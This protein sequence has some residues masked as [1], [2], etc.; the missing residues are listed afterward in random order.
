M[1][2]IAFAFALAILP[3]LAPLPASGLIMSGRGNQPVNDAGWPEG[4]LAMA[5]FE[6]RIG[7]WEGP[8]FGGGES[9]FLFC[10]NTEGFQDAL[11]A[12]AAIRAP[13]LDLVIHDGPYEDNILK[14][15]VDWAF[16]V[17][18]PASWRS[19]EHTSE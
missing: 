3:W 14:E 5:N 18:V 4:A 19:E 10:G 2:R 1:K 17:W 11:A 13:G 16:I 12:F 8:P 9:H 15:R 7:W 6:S